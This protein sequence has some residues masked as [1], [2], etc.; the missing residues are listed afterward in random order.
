MSIDVGVLFGRFAVCV[1]TL[2]GTI[3]LLF[4]IGAKDEGWSLRPGRYGKAVVFAL[5]L[6][7][8]VFVVAADVKSFWTLGM[9]GIFGGCLLTAS[10]M[11]WWEQ[12]VYRFVWWIGGM[13]GAL[14]AVEAGISADACCS[15]LLF[16]VIQEMWFAK[17]YGRADCHAFCVS[18]LVLTA[19]GRSFQDY[20]IHMLS[21]YVILALMQMIRGN[22]SRDG[23]L[24][25]AVPLLPYITI[26]FWLWVDFGGRKW[27]I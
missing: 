10:I 15:M 23:N 14:M 18:S 8:A 7:N 20:V 17:F 6:V 24:K 1:F 22:I 5:C 27:Y 25:K 16:W 21:V 9:L 4:Y 12:M 26:A 11:D 13:A 19:L 3:Y 2:A